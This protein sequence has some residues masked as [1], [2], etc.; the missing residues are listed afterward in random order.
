MLRYYL[1]SFFMQSTTSAVCPYVQIFLRNMGFPQTVVGIFLAFGQIAGT[2]VP[3]EIGAMVDK[4]G[5]VK[6]TLYV[7][8]FCMVASFI[9]MMFKLP[10]LPLAVLYATSQAF[11][12]CLDPVLDSYFTSAFK[13]DPKLYSDVRSSGTMGYVVMLCLFALTGFPSKDSN[14]QILINMIFFFMVFA[15]FVLIAPNPQN[16]GKIGAKENERFKISWLDKSFYI[17]MFIIMFTKISM[18]V[19]DIMLSSYMTEVL[20]LGEKFSLFLAFGAFCEFIAFIVFGDMLKKGKITIWG[21][22][23][24][25]FFGTFLRFTLY[26]TTSS[27]F[28]FAVAQSLHS[29]SFGCNHIAVTSYISKTVPERHR[30][31]A[32]SIY[33]SIAINFSNM[34]GVLFGGMLIDRVG[35]SGV[36]II[37]SVLPLISA[38]LCIYFRKLINSRLI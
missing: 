6:R 22:L 7:C 10:V 11:F 36:F 4:N 38:A 37:Y 23:M 35:Y 34:I 1:L 20:E 30:N 15:F 28:M 5:K 21:L 29:L 27:V 25:S 12:K 32:M 3:L 18:G 2:V 16:A 26:Y 33:F 8:V 9:C 14:T 17:L 13:G 24:L 19:I 31:L